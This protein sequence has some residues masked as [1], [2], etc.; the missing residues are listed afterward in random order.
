MLQEP[1]FDSVLVGISM[2]VY[3]VLSVIGLWLNRV[4][5]QYKPLRPEDPEEEE[6]GIEMQSRGQDGILLVCLFICVGC[7]MSLHM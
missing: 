4:S 3:M 1:G 7:T 2:V 6:E 5:D